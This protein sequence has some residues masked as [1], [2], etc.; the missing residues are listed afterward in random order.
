MNVKSVFT[1]KRNAKPARGGV[2]EEERPEQRMFLPGNGV[3][4]IH[5]EPLGGGGGEES[6]RKIL[7]NCLNRPKQ[8]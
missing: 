3:R 4:L 6:P 1:T 2:E 5:R 7:G 8:I